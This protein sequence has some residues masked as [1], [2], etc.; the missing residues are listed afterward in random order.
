MSTATT[1]PETVDRTGDRVWA[2]VAGVGAGALLARSVRRLR[3]ADGFSH[4][5]SLAFMTAL[6]AVQGIV[7]IVGI[8]TA[9]GQDGVGRAVAEISRLAAPGPVGEA[10]QATIE[11]ARANGGGERYVA[12]GVGLVG[13]LVSAT[14]AMGQVQRSLD[15]L[16]GIERDRPTVSKY[17]RAL[18]LTLS[19]GVLLVTAF[20][21]IALGAA[22]GRSI[23]DNALTPVWAVIRVPLA[24]AL[25]AVAVAVL[26]RVCPNRRQPSWSWLAP[27]A[28]V[29]VAGWCLVTVALGWALDLSPS[30]GDAYGPLA[31][32]VALLLWGL[33]SSTAI[34][35]GAAVMA[36][37][38]SARSNGPA[39]RPD[40]GGQRRRG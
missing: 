27:G 36:E 12:I 11:Q 29:A 34:L 13:V 17:G 10:L 20:A 35:F 3:A 15:R 7:A 8:A 37:V 5:R 6:V 4:A 40:P 16:Y 31:G 33:L 2:T 38:E 21:L 1:V 9:V 32:V 24:V 19:T 26:F 39:G 22:I 14:T 30:F 23:D 28:G 18:V 25:L